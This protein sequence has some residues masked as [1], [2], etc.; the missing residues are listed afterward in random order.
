MP[1]KKSLLATP[2]GIGVDFGKSEPTTTINCWIPIV[3]EF[4]KETARTA[5]EGVRR[6]SRRRW[7]HHPRTWTANRSTW[8]ALKF[9]VLPLVRDPLSDV[10]LISG[11]Y[12]DGL[13]DYLA[14]RHLLS[15]M[16]TAASARFFTLSRVVADIRIGAL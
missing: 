2:R 16:A 10:R 3:Y 8:F 12:C 6:R 14:L 4:S 13:M 1:R 15:L 5:A 11:R 7:C 9:R